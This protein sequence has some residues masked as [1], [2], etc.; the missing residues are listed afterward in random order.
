M[1]RIQDWRLLTGLEMGGGKALTST[2]K[3]MFWKQQ[4]FNLAGQQAVTLG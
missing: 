1:E 3:Q 4:E 2:E